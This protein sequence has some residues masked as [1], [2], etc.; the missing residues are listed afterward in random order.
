[1]DGTREETIIPVCFP[2]TLGNGETLPTYRSLVEN[3]V[4]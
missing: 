4:C 3:P 1:M 2:K